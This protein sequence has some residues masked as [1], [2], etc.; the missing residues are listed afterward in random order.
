[1][2]HDVIARSF[3]GNA[4]LVCYFALV[5][6]IATG[7]PSGGDAVSGVG[8]TLSMFSLLCTDVLEVISCLQYVQWLQDVN[9]HTWAGA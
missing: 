9:R 8:F 6:L 7:V 4:L 2:H 3:S 5:G 1:M